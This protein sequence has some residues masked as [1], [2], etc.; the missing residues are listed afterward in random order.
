MSS[1]DKKNKKRYRFLFLIA[2]L[3]IL[4]LLVIIYTVD[5]KLTAYEESE[6]IPV[7][8]YEELETE[9]NTLQDLIAVDDIWILD[10]RPEK[11]LRGYKDLNILDKNLKKKVDE[12]IQRIQDILDSQED[13]ELTK[14]NMRTELNNLQQEKDSISVKLDSLQQNF[15]LTS[16]Q[17]KRTNDSLENE[18]SSKT[19]QLDRKETLKVIS[20]KSENDVL[21]H[22]IGETKGNEADGSGVGVWANGSIYRGEWTNNRRNGRGEFKWSDGARYEGDFVMGERTGEGTFYYPTGEKYEGQF[23]KG[24]RSGSGTL[25]DI[26]GNVSFEGR[27]EKDKP[28]Q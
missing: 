18:L 8:A 11:A 21:I 7:S 10:K 22:Y 24:L 3:T 23:K 6:T 28:I 19:R 26:D 25:Y 16:S 14:I 9:F 15:K 20:F 1:K 12:R 2:L 13:D 17:L 5:S 4:G 27:W